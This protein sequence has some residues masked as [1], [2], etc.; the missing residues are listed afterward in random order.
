MAYLGKA[1]FNAGGTTIHSALLMSFNKSTFTPL[2]NETIDTL[3]KHYK[4][5]QV[6][7]IDETSL[8][9]SHFLYS[10]DKR[11]REIKHCP[12]NFFGGIDMIV[13]VDFF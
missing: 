8:I 11:M 12:K 6:L 13:C 1:T 4:E 3:Q 9:G 2:S 7:L 10:I 5:L